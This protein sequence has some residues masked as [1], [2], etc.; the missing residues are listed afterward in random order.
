MTQSLRTLFSTVLFISF[1][2][3][4]QKGG[5]F[6][7]HLACDTFLTLLTS[8]YFMSLDERLYKKS[9]GRKEE[10]IVCKTVT[11]HFGRRKLTKIVISEHS[12]PCTPTLQPQSTSGTASAHPQSHMRLLIDRVIQPCS[13]TINIVQKIST[14][15]F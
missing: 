13:P 5:G 14:H 12:S 6:E 11:Q 2:F 10:R 9:E 8:R 1:I 3:F 15:V 7:G 4:L